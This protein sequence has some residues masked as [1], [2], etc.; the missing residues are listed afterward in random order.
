MTKYNIQYDKKYIKDLEKIPKPF[1][2]LIHEK[3][4]ALALNPRPEGSIKLQGSNKIPLYRLRCGDYRVIYTIKDE[5]L[6]ILILELGHRKEI[7]R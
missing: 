5:V 6:L 3:V 4:V 2:R 1:R 7:Y